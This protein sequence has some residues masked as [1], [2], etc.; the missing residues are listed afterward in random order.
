MS[1]TPVTANVHEALD[2]ELD[3]GTKFTFHFEVL[4]NNLPDQVYLL[5]CPVLNLGVLINTCLFKDFL[6]CTAS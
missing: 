1:H 6:S 4:V 2:I 5:I 3:L